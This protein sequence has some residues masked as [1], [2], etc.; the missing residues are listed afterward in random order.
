MQNISVIIPTFNRIGLLSE[1]INSVNSQL[2]QPLEIIVVDDAS[3]DGTADWVLSQHPKINLITITK[4]N[5]AAAARNIGIKAA[6]GDLI[7]FL[8]CDDIWLPNYLL[9]QQ[10]FLNL[11]PNLSGVFSSHFNT[12][13]N[14]EKTYIR[15]NWPLLNPRL[16]LIISNNFIHTMSVVVFKK[17]EIIQAGGLNEKLRICHDRE[18]YIKILKNSSIGYNPLFLVNRRFSSDQLTKNTRLW[19]SEALYIL[20]H[21]FNNEEN[22]N[23]RIYFHLSFY[24]LNMAFLKRFEKE[25]D[26]LFTVRCMILVRWHKIISRCKYF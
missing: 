8:D 15:H 13:S 6:K 16:H 4:N 18:L 21:F 2:C 9:S 17:A 10:A 20:K 3:T 7:A 23:L 14:G 11:H 22:K 19:Y 1:A 5:G 25:N 26:L 24:R 12:I